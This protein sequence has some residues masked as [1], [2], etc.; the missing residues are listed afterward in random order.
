MIIQPTSLAALTWLGAASGTTAESWRIGVV[1][2]AR[3]LG[4]TDQGKIVLQVGGMTVEADL[5]GQSGGG[6]DPRSAL[7]AGQTQTALPAQ[8]QVRV[9]SLGSQ[10]TLEVMLPQAG[11]NLAQVALRERLPQQNGFAPLLAAVQTLAQRPVMRQLPPALRPLLAQL[12]QAM[13]SPA[14]VTTGAGLRE[15]IARS[16]LFLESNL[17][18]GAQ[19]AA[20]A[21]DDDWKAVLL[22]LANLLDSYAPPKGSPLNPGTASSTPADGDTPPPLMQRGMQAQ[23]RAAN[24]A[25]TL[26]ALA[27][28]DDA[29]PLLGQL[30]TTVRAALARIEVAQLEAGTVPAWIAEIPVKGR[31]GHDVL[32]LQLDYPAAADDDTPRQWTLGFAIDLPALGPVQGELQLHDLRL[33]VRLWAERASTTDRLEQ[34]FTALRHRL[35]ACGLL[36][37]QLSCQTGLP[38]ASGRPGAHLLK[39]TA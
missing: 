33:S 10:P 35:A 22:K 28:E 37:D 11:E 24:T 39:A 12:E 17:A 26:A 16:G 29:G 4:V 3:P 18:Q 13:R 1:L 19:L 27:T 7:L 32:Q 34:Q 14:D 25:A 20:G 6:T 30:H 23:A 36:L 8:F 5:S 38:R 9:L 2:S 31:D 15:A 21:G